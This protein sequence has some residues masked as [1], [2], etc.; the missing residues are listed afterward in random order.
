M[1]IPSGFRLSSANF[2]LRK[3]SQKDDA[4]L[5]FCEQE[6][7]AAAVF[8]KNIFAGAPVI[9]NKK[10]LQKSGGKCRAILVNTV[11]SNAGTGEI[12]REN[13]AKIQKFLAEKVGENL[14][15]IL[16]ASTGIIGQQ[17]P[18]EKFLAGIPEILKNFDDDILRAGRAIL[19]TDLVEKIFFAKCGDAKILGIAKGSGM[20]APNMATMLG[21]FL[22][23]AKIDPQ[24]LQKK[25]A[26][27]CDETFNCV[28]VDNCESTS[29]AAFVLSSQKIPV[30]EKIF[31]E[32][33]FLAAQNLSKKIAADGEGA[34]HLISAI[35]KNCATKNSAKK[36]S[37]AV[38]KSDLLKAAIC[39]HDANWGRILAAIGATRENFSP[40]KIDIFFD[41][42]K[43]FENGAPKNFNEKKIFQNFEVKIAI[44]FK[45][46]NFSAES[47]GCDLTKKYVEINSE[48]ST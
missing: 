26:E 13:A 42:E 18:P 15:K 5:I 9:L 20:I 14:E 43:V 17:L 23:D 45:N 47:F 39:G 21:F 12:G 40:E 2:G 29:D 10:S 7:D 48:Y 32:Q 37:R 34:T 22:T 36:L 41:G 30:D 3:N 27:I 25:W 16:L 19:T 46:G 35:A 31:F 44:D 24:K 38:V 4:C 28:S 8:T 1:E 6:C 33:L 11:F